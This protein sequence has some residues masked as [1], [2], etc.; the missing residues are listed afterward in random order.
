MVRSADAPEGWSVTWTDH[1]VLVT[2]A[3]GFIGGRVCE[4]LFQAGVRRI[5]ALVHSPHHASRVARLPIELC[6]GSLL[7]QESLR[8]ALGDAKIVIHCG[9]GAA[10]GIVTGTENLL[11]TSAEAGVERFI[12]MSTA[13]V[14]G[15]TPPPGTETEDAPTLATGNGYCDNKARAE[16]SVLRFFKQ[17]LPAVILRPSIVYGPYSAWSTRLVDDL[18]NQ[19]VAFIDGGRGACNTTYVENLIDAVFLSLENDA[20]LG[21]TFFITDGE[22]IT[23]GDFIRAHIAMMNPQPKVGDISGEVIV[24]YYRRRPGIVMGSLKAS[25]RALRSRE[26][27]QLLMQVP[28]TE[29]ALTRVWAWMASLPEERR[30]RL[31]ARLGV[32]RQPVG[33]QGAETFMPDETTL[34]TQTGTVFFRID[35][36]RQVL[37]FE[38]RVPFRQGI[39]VVEQWLRYANYL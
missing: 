37:G 5:R 6:R 17:G 14:Y 24:D 19:R 32:R 13:A 8:L 3:T 22:C 25:G 28:V 29:K 39:N 12:H 20:A 33:K 18:R 27:R 4:R 10:N 9:L 38:P 15:L 7:D 31:R 16:R 1:A 35:R 21:Q 11:R 34:A 26:L 23:W 36:A 2:G 30:E